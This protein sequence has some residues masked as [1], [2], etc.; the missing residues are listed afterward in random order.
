MIKKRD[1]YKKYSKDMKNYKIKV[2][3]MNSIRT[4]QNEKIPLYSEKTKVIQ[5]LNH[6][7]K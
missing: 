2:Y 5:M 7:I 4:E 1:N 6:F 3:L